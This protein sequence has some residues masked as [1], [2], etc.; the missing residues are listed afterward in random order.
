MFLYSQ[1]CSLD[2]FNL[3]KEKREILSQF[4]MG[5]KVFQKS[6]S[7]WKRISLKSAVLGRIWIG[8]QYLCKNCEFIYKNNVSPFCR[9]SAVVSQ[10]TNLITFLSNLAQCVE[11]FS[12]G[13]F[14]YFNAHSFSTR[15]LWNSQA[16]WMNI[17]VTSLE[18][19]SLAEFSG[20]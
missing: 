1:D 17:R 11:G 2:N 12:K 20:E 14:K 9:K 13:A 8:W 6:H 3:L 15:D 4:T 5:D 16:W 19:L 7:I 18:Q 10:A